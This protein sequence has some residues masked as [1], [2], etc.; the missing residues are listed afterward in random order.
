MES[1][2]N[3]CTYACMLVYVYECGWP[4][5][6]YASLTFLH[7]RQCERMSKKVTI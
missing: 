5:G 3:G 4:S 1:K 2:K 6:I 7:T